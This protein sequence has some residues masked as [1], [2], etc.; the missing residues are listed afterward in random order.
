MTFFCYLAENFLICFHFFVFYIILQSSFNILSGPIRERI[1]LIKDRREE[2]SDDESS[3]ETTCYT[4]QLI[5][6]DFD[7]ENNYNPIINKS[8][9]IVARTN[10]KDTIRKFNNI[11]ELIKFYGVH[12]EDTITYF[13]TEDNF[14]D[15]HLAELLHKI[16][17]TNFVNSN[18]DYR[19]SSIEEISQKFITPN[20]YKHNSSW[21][22]DELILDYSLENLKT[23]CKVKGEKLDAMNSIYRY[24]TDDFVKKYH[25]GKIKED[26]L[27]FERSF[28]DD[29]E[30][31]EEELKD[32]TEFEC[33]NMY[34]RGMKFIFD[35]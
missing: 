11:V 35:F 20:E 27:M 15:R 28:E 31:T 19:T 14:K 22:G 21:F 24:L 13:V 25:T 30:I 4:H 5:F 34:L 2:V 3:V 8:S 23:F 33:K 10:G 18:P 26:I 32:R 9:N 7:L 16:F 29:S 12:E 17:I 6:I 1:L